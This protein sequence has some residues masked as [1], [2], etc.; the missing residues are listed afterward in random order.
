MERKGKKVT[1]ERKGGGEGKK[2]WEKGS[3]Q[4]RLWHILNIYHGERKMNLYGGK[5]NQTLARI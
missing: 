5:I 1:K 4:S 3:K 2:K